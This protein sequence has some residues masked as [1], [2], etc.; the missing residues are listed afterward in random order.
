MVDGLAAWN[1]L[2]SWLATVSTSWLVSVGMVT[3]KLAGMS[4]PVV[5]MRLRLWMSHAY[6][7]TIQVEETGWL[8][9]C[10]LLDLP[11]GGLG[12]P[13]RRWLAGECSLDLPSGRLGLSKMHI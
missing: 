7:M 12:C 3:L 9:C 10:C 11:S 8:A 13:G 2:A 1:D 5:W 6:H 4:H